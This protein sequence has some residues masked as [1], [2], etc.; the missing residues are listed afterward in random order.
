MDAERYNN[1]PP[2]EK[3]R[4]KLTVPCLF[5]VINRLIPAEEEVRLITN[6]ETPYS[7]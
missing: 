4:L 5:G 6:S 2:D 7:S 3:V 1:I